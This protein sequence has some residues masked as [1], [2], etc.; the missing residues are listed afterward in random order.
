MD[1]VVGLLH[2]VLSLVRDLDLDKGEA[3]L[4]VCTAAAAFALPRVGSKWFRKV[5]QWGSEFARRRRL[6]VLAVGLVALAARAAVLPIRPILQPKIQDEFS[7]LLAAETFAHGRLTNPTYRTRTHFESIHI[8][9]ETHLYVNVLPGPRAGHGGRAGNRR[10]SLLGGVVQPGADV[11]GSLLDAGKAGC[12]PDSASLG[13]L[14][15]CFAWQ[16][17]AI[18]ATVIG[19][20]PLRLQVGPGCLGPCLG[21]G[22]ATRSGC[23]FAGPGIG[24]PGQQSA[25]RRL[26]SWLGRGHGAGSVAPGEKGAGPLC[27]CLASRGARAHCP[28]SDGRCDGLLL[29]RVTGSPFH[30]P[31]F[32]NVESY[33]PGLYF[34]WQAMRALPDY[35]HQVIEDHYLGWEFSQYQ[36]AFI[37]SGRLAGKKAWG[38]IRFFL[39]LSSVHARGRSA[40]C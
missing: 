35:H 39:G 29:R 37:Y 8:I 38:I 20:A 32:V 1:M 26:V 27:G 23:P 15:R 40:T 12:R 28:C 24:H 14:P 10:A 30:I 31:Y 13:A 3:L 17:S 22:E 4:V 25:V 16:F 7:Y 9:Q 36:F 11:R 18:G 2:S 6:A 5:E 21:L 34:P 33:K 19:E